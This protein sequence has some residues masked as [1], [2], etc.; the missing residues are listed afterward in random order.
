MSAD[1]RSSRAKSRD[2]TI[3]GLETLKQTP[4][5]LETLL[6]AAPRAA[7]DW[8]PNRKRWSISQ[9]LAHLA[10]VEREGFRV[11]VEQFVKG[12]ALGVYDQN[13]QAA[14]GTYSGKSVRQSLARFKRERAKSLALLR[15]LP[16]GALER[17]ARHPELGR[18]SL[19][20][21]MHEWAFHDL[22][23]IRQVAELYRSRVHFPAMGGW[24]R[25]YRINP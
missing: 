11:R 8:K 5:I 1:R 25:Y 2:R 6:T 17:R 18:V 24:T 12:Q 23:H 13:A 7:F 4:K 19:R 22:G 10:H 3:P 14:A 16:R 9:V 15:K 21:M 20:Q